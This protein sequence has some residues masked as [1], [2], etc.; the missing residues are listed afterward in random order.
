MRSGAFR[1]LQVVGPQPL[2]LLLGHLPEIEHR[3]VCS[4]RGPDQLVQLDLYGCPVAVLGVLDQEDHEEGQDRR[5]GV[6]DE[7]RKCR[8]VWVVS[9]MA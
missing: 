1:K 3:V 6:D 2:Q 5:A 7:L 9:P 4:P 8:S